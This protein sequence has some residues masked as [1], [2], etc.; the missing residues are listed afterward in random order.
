MA[1][2]INTSNNQITKQGTGHHRG[3]FEHTHAVP[4]SAHQA[5]GP[6]TAHTWPT[7]QQEEIYTK[8]QF[9]FI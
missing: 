5:P 3:W 7:P 2:A 9:H 6:T 8:A 4:Q 1:T